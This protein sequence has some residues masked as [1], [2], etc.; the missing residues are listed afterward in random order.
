MLAT[1]I[2]R[3]VLVVAKGDRLARSLMTLSRLL[4]DSDARGWSLVALDLGVDTSTPAGRLAIQVIGAAAEYESRMIG[5]R[6]RGN[7][8][9]QG[10]RCDVRMP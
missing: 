5:A 3:Y 6:T 7:G 1:I 8:R 4:E 2:C 10:Q 9:T